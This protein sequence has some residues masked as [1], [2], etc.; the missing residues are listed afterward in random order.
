ML[1]A[2][3]LML[4]RKVAEVRGCYEAFYE[5]KCGQNAARI[6]SEL[7][8]LAFDDPHYLRM[9]YKP[10]CLLHN[11]SRELQLT[12]SDHDYSMVKKLKN[13]T[14]WLGDVISDGK[15][16]YAELNGVAPRSSNTLQLTSY[17]YSDRPYNNN[18]QQQQQWTTAGHSSST[19][20]RVNDAIITARAPMVASLLQDTRQP[21]RTKPAISCAFRPHS[22]LI[23]SSILAVIVTRQAKFN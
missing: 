17:F 5:A 20:Y 3:L 10:N 2:T 13:E 9:R 7:V 12:S 1:V 15:D 11:A 19:N 4:C 21:P 6:M 8:E 23:T 22:A 14:I 16:E 18:S